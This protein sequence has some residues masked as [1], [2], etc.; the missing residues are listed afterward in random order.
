[1]VDPTTTALDFVTRRFPRASA[2][3]LGGGTSTGRRTAT[4]DLDLVVVLDGP[5]APFRETAEHD[6]V[7]VELFCHTVESFEV[8]T[9]REIA[10]R[11][12]PLLH[13]CGEG[14]LLLDREGVGRR[15]QDAARAR[16]AAGPP[17]LTAEELEDLRYRVTDLVDD[18]ADATDPDE[19][20]FIANRLLTSAGGLVLA[21]RRRWQS[22]GKW[23][24][25][26]LRE[27]DPALCADVLR[28]YRESVDRTD[29]APFARVVGRVLDE[30]GGRVLV[31]Y[32]RT[33]DLDDLR[34][35]RRRTAGGG[36]D[37]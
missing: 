16:L 33:A 5:P 22:N 34:A 23:L 3:I 35:A 29:P 30:A 2:A 21:A 1:M 11:R 24:L 9:D 27:A 31:G 8:F 37:R 32:R 20:L 19:L 18:L 13:M 17:P 28:A 26:R 14:V 10:A 25:R 12:S 6:G 7:P 36:H 15:V 4:S